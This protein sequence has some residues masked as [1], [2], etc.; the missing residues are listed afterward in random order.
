MKRISIVCVGLATTV[1]ASAFVCASRAS[2]Q[3]TTAP[4]QQQ[5]LDS[6]FG[7]IQ[8]DMPGCAAA[9]LQDG[10]LTSIGAYGL[11]D[12]ENKVPITINSVFDIGSIS[13][14]FTAMSILMLADRGKLNLDDE[15]HTYLPQLPRYSAPVTIAELLHQTSGID[16]YAQLLYL[17]G[18]DYA[19]LISG[20]NILWVIQ[21]QHRLTFR[22]GTR[23][24]YSDTN[25]FLLALVVQKV[26]GLQLE[27][28]LKENIFNP[29]GMSH[30]VL[31]VD[32]NQLISGK[33]W[34]YGVEDNAPS[35]QQGIT[36]TRGDGGI[37]STIGD[38]AL[39]DENFYDP[40]V[41][42]ARVIRAMQQLTNLAD[43]TTNYYAGGL[44][45]KDFFGLREV[46]HAGGDFGYQADLLRLPQL[47]LS[48]IALCNRSDIGV[49]LRTQRM[50]APYVRSSSF[51]RPPPT[52][53]PEVS[54]EID[55][56]A[57]AGVYWSPDEAEYRMF[58][59]SNNTLI[60]R[61]LGGTV[62]SP[63]PTA[64]GLV[65][66]AI[67][68]RTFEN[69][70]NATYQFQLDR[71]GRATGMVINYRILRNPAHV[72]FQRVPEATVDVNTLNE[73]AGIYASTEVAAA[74]CMYPQTGTLMLRRAHVDDLALTP[75]FKDAFEADNGELIFQRSNG[76]ITGITARNMRVKVDDFRKLSN[77]ENLEP[78]SFSCPSSKAVRRS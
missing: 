78:H 37:F 9:I 6:V 69:G 36:E 74:W 13:K 5:R 3:N 34:P 21:R 68:P 42:N 1:L 73:Y 41:G 44:F 67:G 7:D 23:F 77:A 33:V 39:W 19:D 55:L 15:I 40:K 71:K 31:R 57:L 63:G 20:P 17:A 53:D 35:L 61:S 45:I 52:P 72:F 49:T 38:L 62:P 47:H 26:S 56:R 14:Q 27:D 8:A 22:P 75:L 64:S 66:R 28:F 32:H 2:A 10:R 59:A 76:S 11:A 58:S 43:G 50:V 54:P 48:A 51:F 30:T 46:E 65:Y 24:S 29:L 25:Y 60:D 16:D 18:W 4:T 70:V 12:V